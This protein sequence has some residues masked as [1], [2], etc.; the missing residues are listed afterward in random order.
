MDFSIVYYKNENFVEK[1]IGEEKVLVPL[2]D[3]VADM[4]HVFT[5]NSVGSF[6]YDQIDGENSLEVI[7][8]KVLVEFDVEKEI[9]NND[10]EQ[11]ILSTVEK[12]IIEKRG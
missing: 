2:S 9:A 7:F 5:M 4:N 1:D 12:G 8:N 3:N 11:F 10:F 6:I